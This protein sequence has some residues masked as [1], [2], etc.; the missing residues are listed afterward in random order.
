[1]SNENNH[2]QAQM[3]RGTAWLTAS[4][5]ISRLL[6]AI[7]IIPW[8]IWMG[9]YAAKANGLFT[10]GYNI[11]A[12]FL[13][14]STA[15]IPVA[16]A[17]QVAKYNTMQEEEHSFAL[18]RSFLGF[19]TGLGLVFALVLYLF[20]PWLADLSG[21]GKDLI[22]IMQSLAWAVL[23]FP[24]MSVIRG[25]FQG[26]N[27]LKPYAMSQIA[28]QVIR[29]IWM[30]L[31]TFIIMKLGS[32]D[33]LAAVTQS[34]FAAFV[35]MVASFAVLLYFLYKE[36]MLQKV[37][38]TRDKIDSK[39]LLMDTIKEAIPFIITGSAIQLFQ[40]LDQMTF[41][42]S[43]KWFT[44]YNNEDLVV[45]FSYF[46]ANPNKITMILISVGVS[47][48]SVGLPL[49]TENY[50]KGDLPAAARLVQNSITML[51]LF[52]LPATVGVVMVGEPL[53]TVFYGKPD[54]L[55]MGLFVFAVLQSTILGL[56]MVLS[57]MLQAMFRNRKAVL[58]FVYG[59]IAKIVLQLP[60]IA[61]FH[62][63][64]PL[65]STTI[66]L[67][68]PIVLMYREICQITG[69][70]R[71]IILK[72]T[73]LVIIL[74]LVMFILVGFLQWMIG[75]VFQPNGRFWSFI[76]VALIGTIGGGLY[77]FMS[78]YTRLLDKVIG[79]AKADQL[80]ARLKLS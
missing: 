11:Y 1:M 79:Q 40:I 14:I 76:Y 68:I 32:G 7:Y 12:W 15:G 51:F 9:T 53:Y 57:P 56:Y 20:A 2:Q 55:A 34:T 24:S 46:S 78:L 42:N 45:M 59:S 16:V 65:I 67:I 70:H 49:L 73:I 28:E 69:V 30:L 38:E 25:F 60:S 10:M 13:L 27:N 72:R 6:G 64:G 39:H 63:Y 8:Y 21:V 61:L 35:G 75:F 17:K 33:Y 37:F 77:G 54:S 50:V 29:V 22:P 62:S 4:N 23:I 66:G 41:I 5:F 58:Y 80:R 71:K 31:A 47:I 43:M 18:I 52:L 48:G 26:M 3:L 44:N 19:M 36:G 74:T